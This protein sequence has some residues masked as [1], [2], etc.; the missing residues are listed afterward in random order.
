VGEQFT[1]GG[2]G[3]FATSGK[4]KHRCVCTGKLGDFLATATAGIAIII[5]GT[6][7]QN[8]F[9]LCGASGDHSTDSRG[10]GALSLWERG[11]FNVA[12]AIYIAVL[13]D[14]SRANPKLRVG[15]VGVFLSL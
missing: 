11:V 2:F 1:D 9:N 10:F 6:G 5:I 7:Y 14:D 8:L 15:S 13:G 4:H 3:A 12:A